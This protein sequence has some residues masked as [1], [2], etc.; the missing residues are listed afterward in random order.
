MSFRMKISILCILLSFVFNLF[1]TVKIENLSSETRY[2]FTIDSVNFITQNVG[3]QDFSK[4]KFVGV[5]GHQGIMF[6]KGRPEIPV[7]RLSV[8]AENDEDIQIFF[9]ENK[10]IQEN[11]L[12]RPLYPSQESIPK[13]VGS[14]INFIKIQS[15]YEVKE[16]LPSVDY[17]IDNSG[18]VNGKQK[19]LITVYPF[20]YKANSSQYKI[21]ASFTV[22]VKK[23][24]NKNNT[25]NKRDVFAFIV[26]KNYADSESFK[27]YVNFKRKIGYQTETIVVDRD[28][29]TTNEIRAKLQE[30][31]NN[32]NN[33][34]KY[35]LIIG[36]SEDVPAKASAH[37]SGI[38]DH[39]YRAIDTSDYENDINGPDIG[40]GRLTVR[41]VTELD[42][43]IGKLLK[44]QIGD[45]QNEQWLNNVSFIATDDRYTI[46]EGSHN[47]VIDNYTKQLG[48]TGV[49][50]ELDNLGGDKLY[51][52][53]HNVSDKTVIDTM[54]L[55]RTVINYS[56]HGSTVGW[57]GPH[58]SQRDVL[59][60]NHS[61][62][63]PFVISN[64]CI[65]GQFTLEESFAETW[66]KHPQGAITF[67]GSMDNT[68]WDE[69]D[70]LEKNMYNAIYRDGKWDFAS[71]TNQALTEVWNYYGGANRSKYYWETYVIFGD[72]SIHLRKSYTEE[73][74]I[75]G[76]ENIIFGIDSIKLK[77][78]D[79]KKN[80]ISGLKVGVELVGKNVFSSVVS[81]SEGNITL[82]IP[83][84]ALVTDELKLTIYG[85][86]FKTKTKS[87]K[88]LSSNFP[89]LLLNNVSISDRESLSISPGE[90]VKLNMTV[91]NVSPVATTGGQVWI[92]TIDG[93]AV[94]VNYIED[95]PALGHNEVYQINSPKFG[96]RVGSGRNAEKVH[97]IFGWNTFEGQ[98]GII[99]RTF[100]FKRGE[101]AISQVDFGDVENPITG[102]LGPGDIGDVFFTV[103]NTG[104]DI[105]RDVIINMNNSSCLID[106]AGELNI[107]ALNVGETRR[108]EY[109]LEVKVDANCENDQFASMSFNGDHQGQYVRENL[110]AN[111]SFIIGR[112]GNMIEEY[113]DIFIP[114]LD[115]EV[116]TFEIPVD[117][118]GSIKDISF[119][120]KL[121]HSYVGDLEITVTSPSGLEVNIF[122]REGGGEDNL[123]Q[124]FGVEGN[125][126]EFINTNASGIWKIKVFDRGVS[127][128]GVLDNISINILGYVN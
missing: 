85:K 18:S 74:S 7:I 1:A 57:A 78:V 40:V 62:A 60:L 16:Y 115:N 14:K 106:G 70:I 51:A 24:L 34:L 31:Y 76:P 2:H 118:I 13:I 77:L 79:S 10:N 90:N 127:D 94:P 108:I 67:W 32:P 9:D 66:I 23:S 25:K 38:T 53:T 84:E 111:G 109:P 21:N 86:N 17:K 88:I 73:V 98:S 6:D 92:K 99:N 15:A 110:S 36:D 120:I 91:Q 55:G 121:T 12:D 71:I 20:K 104:S 102:S 19:K 112:L 89:F 107:G 68:Y 114:I 56:G 33:N 30:I 39:Y 103:T 97:V 61:D 28:V 96:F 52:I 95:I 58:V 113:S 49:F 41:T 100:S 8:F 93:N 125:L 117:G 101:L 80:S 48:Y 37:I 123:D 59:S 126:S 82:K 83:E 29:K 116:S 105:L 45:F 3:G 75:I 64:A 46:A 54:N 4:A 128:E 69:D 124:V 47:Y 5:N 122:N 119:G 63:R 11:N 26:G 22:I 43:V 65:T 50:P 72:P 35:A 44:Y 81:D 87:L 42:G 27:T